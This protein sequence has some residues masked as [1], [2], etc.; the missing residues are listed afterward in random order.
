VRA[1]T[2]GDELARLA[3]TMNVHQSVADLLKNSSILSR[4]VAAGSL[5]VIKAVYRLSSGAVVRL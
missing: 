5:A 1:L 3:I 2:S 4:E